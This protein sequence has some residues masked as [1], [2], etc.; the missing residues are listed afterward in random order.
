M[1]TVDEVAKYLTGEK[2]RGKAKGIQWQWPSFNGISQCEMH[3]KQIQ[4]YQ[5]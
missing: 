2:L 5:R 4:Y 1:T 3:E